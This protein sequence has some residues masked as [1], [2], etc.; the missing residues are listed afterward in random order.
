MLWGKFKDVIT[1]YLEF[2]REVGWQIDLGV[3]GMLVL[4]A[5]IMRELA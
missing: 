1:S 2:R 5:A 4:A 3:L